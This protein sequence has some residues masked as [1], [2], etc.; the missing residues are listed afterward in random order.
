MH[1][2]MSAIYQQLILVQ[3]TILS[4]CE[5]RG[6]WYRYKITIAGA[7]IGFYVLVSSSYA[8]AMLK[9][10]THSRRSF[11]H[12]GELSRVKPHPICIDGPIDNL[13]ELDHTNPTKVSS[14]SNTWLNSRAI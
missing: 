14:L 3:A 2:G 6:V 5:K 9:Q 1:Q 10:I 8:N 13:T 4:T 12:Y 7:A 11:G